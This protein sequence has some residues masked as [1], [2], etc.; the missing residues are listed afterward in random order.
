[1]KAIYAGSFDPITY[2]HLDVI[3][4][5]SKVFDEVLVV[6]ANNHSKKYRFVDD[7][8]L[9]MVQK[10]VK[11]F[12]GVTCHPKILNHL[13]VE[14]AKEV[15][16]NCLVRG[17]RSEADFNLEMQMSLINKNICGDIQTVFIPTSPDVA[18]LSSSLVREIE[19]YGGDISAFVPP[20]VKEIMRRY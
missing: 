7:V 18:F 15:E 13:L 1:V 19:F 17:L 9:L 12:K 8:R 11:D 10:A 3:R 2:G 4:K 14:F 16:I 6:V 20:E 5:S